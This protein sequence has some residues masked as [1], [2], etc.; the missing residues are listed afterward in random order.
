MRGT[1][2]S[3]SRLLT[4]VVVTLL[5]LTACGTPPRGESPVSGEQVT[6]RTEKGEVTVPVTD[7]GIWA[8]DY[9]TALNLLALGVVPEYAGRYDHD[10]DPFVSA[11]YT[12]LREAGVELV[13]P[14]RAELI[15]AAEPELIVGMP[16]GGNEQIIPRLPDLAPVVI[17]PALPVLEDDLRTLGAVTG[18]QR[19]ATELTARLDAA[20]EELAAKIA[21]SEF[22]GA[23]VSVLSACGLDAF[24]VYGNARGFGPVLDDLGL[25]RPVSQAQEGN[26]W[27]YRLVSPENLQDQT[28]DVVVT[29]TGSVAF[30]APSAFDNSLFD[31]AGAT[32]GEADFSAW[33]GVGPLNHLWVLRD[34]DALFF[35]EHAVTR[36]EDAAELWS[37]VVGR[38]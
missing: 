13:E 36:E 30:G 33:F 18:H 14:G 10:P 21:A 23:S 11:A 38:P 9:Q 16:L 25:R 8:L 19:E 1:V 15:A 35:G 37:E 5:A 29:F 34:L 20:L 22:S 32:K 24:C 31:T 4:I 2:V 17:L 28:A 7:T 27:G 26:E 6:V 12:I 3:R